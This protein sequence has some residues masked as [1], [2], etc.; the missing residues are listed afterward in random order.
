MHDHWQSY[1]NYDDCRHALCNAH[2]LRELQCIE[3]QY[4]QPWAKAMSALLVEI[5]KAVEETQPQAASL[6]A[7]RLADFERRYAAIV[8]EGFAANPSTPLT[9]SEGT[10][11]K[12]GR[13]KSR[14]QKI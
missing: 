5:K 6:P 9:A 2:H 11:K 8:Q 10:G 4:Q 12:R 13:P 3:T 14:S 7:E 1:F